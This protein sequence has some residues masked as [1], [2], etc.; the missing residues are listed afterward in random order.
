MIFN[1]YKFD[2][3]IIVKPFRYMAA[4]SIV[5]QLDTYTVLGSAV[6][7]NRNADGNSSA[8]L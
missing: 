8:K 1:F 3:S 7:D 5:I 6:N 2:T 4:S